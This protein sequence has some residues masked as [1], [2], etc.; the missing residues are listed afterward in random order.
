LAASTPDLPRRVLLSLAVV[1]LAFP[2]LGRAQV[3]AD[4]VLAG[5]VLLGDSTLTSGKVVL[6]LVGEETQSAIDSVSLTAD[7]SFSFRLPSVPD[8]RRSEVYFASVRHD[9]VLYFGNAVSL[10]IQLDSLYEIHAYDTLLA[11]SEGLDLPVQIRNVFLE[12]TE[13]GWQVTDLFQL[14][15]PNDRTLVARE[16]GAV[17]RYPLPIA[18]RDASVSDAMQVAGGA[19]VEDGQI[20]LRAALAPGEQMVVVR[21]TVPDPF[22]E[23]PL[24]GVTEALEVLVREPAPPLEAPGLEAVDRLELEPGSTYRRFSGVDFSDTVVRLVE[25]ESRRSVPPGWL[26]L[27]LALVLGSA[28]VW[29]IQRPAVEVTAPPPVRGRRALL[30]EVA[31]LDERFTA[32]PSPTPEERGAYEARR[33]TLL[34]RLRSAG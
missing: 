15:N 4:P 13:T 6:H 28:G 9:G 19:T 26:A 32:N 33:S 27:L 17:W 2:A 7:G 34:R 22:V 11:P 30:L 31:K 18:A 24:P 5:R 29:I 12:S 1:A 25:G 23:L 10:P 20:V 3:P 8:P 14:G 21:Y 16:G